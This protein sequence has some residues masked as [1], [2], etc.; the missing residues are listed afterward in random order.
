MSQADSGTSPAERADLASG[1]ALL[2]RSRFLG[3]LSA[4]IFLLAALA[5]VDALQTL[6][7]HEFNH[8]DAVPGERILVSGMLPAGLSNHEKMEIHVEGEAGV[9][10]VPFETYKG[11]WMGG[12]MWRAE[13]VIAP[14]ARP[15]EHTDAKRSSL[16]G[17]DLAPGKAFVTIVDYLPLKK[18]G[19]NVDEAVAGTGPQNPALVYSVTIWPTLSAR[20][21]A[22]ISLCRRYTGFPAFLV[23]VV[24]VGFALLAGFANWRTFS[25][26][27]RAL[28]AHGVFFIHG[29][30][31]L[32]QMTR[33]DKVKKSGFKAAF[34]R[35]DQHLAMG[36][37]MLLFDR[38]WHEQSRGVIVEVTDIKAFALFP[39]DG[40]RPQYGWLVTRDNLE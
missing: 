13:L 15:I 11:F 7:R 18:E 34:A 38:D 35:A 37:T 22:D 40:V 12:Q 1:K 39:Q 4:L 26:A 9:S 24:A 23:A 31:D 25:K 30:N 3:R 32:A 27:E 16:A 19:V 5:V 21:A 29:I 6:M 2:A 36:E 14:D 17:Q 20:Q 10:L 8:I 33:T 28:A